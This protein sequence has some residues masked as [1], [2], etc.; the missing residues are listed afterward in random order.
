MPIVEIH[1]QN[2]ETIAMFFLFVCK[3]FLTFKILRN[4]RLKSKICWPWKISFRH[5]TSRELY[6]T[7]Y[8]SSGYTI[9]Y[10]TRIYHVTY[11][12]YTILYYILQ[13]RLYYTIYHTPC[14]ILQLYYTILYATYYTPHC[15]S[16]YTIVRLNYAVYCI[17]NT[18]LYTITSLYSSV[19][20]CY[21]VRFLG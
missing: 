13:F 5:E 4:H 3:N 12:N 21:I 9:I 19:E 7:I 18:L 11:Y 2:I 16:N 15:S 1:T 20:L 17:P 6:Y 14:T 10:S 8:Y